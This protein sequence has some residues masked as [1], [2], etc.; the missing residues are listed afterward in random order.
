MSVCVHTC[1]YVCIYAPGPCQLPVSI[2]L[3]LTLGQALSLSLELTDSGR[4]SSKDPRFYLP[5]AGMADVDLPRIWTQ[6][7]LLVFTLGAI[8]PAHTLPAWFPSVVVKVDTDNTILNLTALTF[9]LHKRKGSRAEVCGVW[10]SRLLC[11]FRQGVSSLLLIYDDGIWVLLNQ[12][13]FSAFWCGDWME[14]STLEG[15]VWSD[16]V[17]MVWVPSTSSLVLLCQLNEVAFTSFKNEVIFA[18]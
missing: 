7:F 10:L 6:V 16:T 17:P 8:L 2:T 14:V 4:L 1:A 9:R 15:T 12:L 18:L 11:P 3:C 5:D 13:K